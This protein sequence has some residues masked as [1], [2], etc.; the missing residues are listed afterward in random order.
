MLLPA[1]R[2]TVS[3]GARPYDRT[4]ALLKWVATSFTSQNDKQ[5]EGSE[6]SIYAPDAFADDESATGEVEGFSKAHCHVVKSV[7]TC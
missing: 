1:N 2:D 4:R 5:E 6:A 7:G 3:P